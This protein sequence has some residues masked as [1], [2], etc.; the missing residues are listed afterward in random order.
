MRFFHVG[1]IAR[2]TDCIETMKNT[3]L[4]IIIGKLIN[5][6]DRLDRSKYKA[7]HKG[8]RSCGTL[9]PCLEFG[10][11]CHNAASAPRQGSAR[12]RCSKVGNCFEQSLV[13]SSACLLLE[14]QA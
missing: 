4:Q 6:Y 13:Y 2:P 11:G 3:T 14:R 5:I 7:N 8:G 12:C 10:K 9:L 1:E